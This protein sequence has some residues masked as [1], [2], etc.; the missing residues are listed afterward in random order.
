MLDH[1]NKGRGPLALPHLH[2]LERIGVRRWKE[3]EGEE[4]CLEA[5]LHWRDPIVRV[6]LLRRHHRTLLDDNPSSG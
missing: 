4:R 6:R 2:V 1:A 3:I 5:M